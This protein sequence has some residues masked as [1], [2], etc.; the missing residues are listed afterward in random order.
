MKSLTKQ[1]LA[2]A[3]ILCVGVGVGGYLGWTL[4]PSSSE[5]LALSALQQLADRQAEADRLAYE[6]LQAQLEGQQQ[7]TDERAA[8]ATSERARAQ[9][10]HDAEVGRLA[11]EAQVA[12]ENAQELGQEAESAKADLFSSRL[13]VAELLADVSSPELTAAVDD[14]R[15]ATEAVITALTDETAQLNVVIADQAQAIRLKN[16]LIETLEN[17]VFSK[18]ASYTILDNRFQAAEARIEKLKG[19]RVNFG[20]SVGAGAVKPL[21]GSW[22]PGTATIV[23]LQLRLW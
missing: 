14:E 20:V 9:Q 12:L 15:V 22:G 7:A 8:T 5:G 3:M 18:D 2:G 1:I 10:R 16:A 11:D 21:S 19:R 17:E 23:S 13:Q 6:T 4:K